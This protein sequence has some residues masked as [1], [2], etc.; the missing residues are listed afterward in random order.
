MNMLNFQVQ[1]LGKLISMYTNNGNCTA[2]D[3]VY[4]LPP[5]TAQSVM[6]MNRESEKVTAYNK[7]NKR[8]HAQTQPP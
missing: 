3:R 4:V 5:C 6:R 2:F 1:V 7:M 8:K